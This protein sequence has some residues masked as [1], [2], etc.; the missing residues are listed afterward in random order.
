MII[1]DCDAVEA[2]REAVNDFRR[3][4]EITEKI[5]PIDWTGV[6]WQKSHAAASASPA[7]PPQED[8]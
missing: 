7:L 8:L 4:Q 2:A 6:F 1:D 5:Q 3:D